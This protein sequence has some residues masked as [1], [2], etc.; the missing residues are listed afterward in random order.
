MAK[1]LFALALTPVHPPLPTKEVNENLGCREGGEVSTFG[2]GHFSH[3]RKKKA[4]KGS[5]N[6]WCVA[7]LNITNFVVVG[8]RLPTTPTIKLDYGEGLGGFGEG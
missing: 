2:G 7:K 6:N 3:F 5:L 1:R 4:F 8:V